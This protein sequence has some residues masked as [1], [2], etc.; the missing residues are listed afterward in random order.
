MGEQMNEQSGRITV[1]M[2]WMSSKIPS[3]LDFWFVHRVMG[4][5]SPHQGPLSIVRDAT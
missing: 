3:N 2:G 4:S 5:S 1:R